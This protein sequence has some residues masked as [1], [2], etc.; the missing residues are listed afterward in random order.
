MTPQPEDHAC[1][2]E[3]CPAAAAWGFRLNR[4]VPYRWACFEHRR[5]LTKAPSPAKPLP[6]AAP[7][8]GDLFGSAR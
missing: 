8:A 5:Q 6:K 3:G 2:V 1:L 7:P 4:D